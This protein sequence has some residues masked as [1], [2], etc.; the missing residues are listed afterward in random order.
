MRV[1]LVII[2]YRQLVLMKGLNKNDPFPKNC[3]LNNL[4]GKDTNS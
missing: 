2:K 3:S 4:K 1:N